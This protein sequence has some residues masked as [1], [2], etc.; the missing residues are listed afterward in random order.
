[1]THSRETSLTS[2]QVFRFASV[3][4]HATKEPR[5]I[6]WTHVY[7]RMHKKGIVG[8]DLAASAASATRPPPS[9]T[10]PLSS[11]DGE[12]GEGGQEG[13][14]CT[15]GW[16]IWPQ[17]VEA[18][19]EGLQSVRAINVDIHP[20]RRCYQHRRYIARPLQLSEG[21]ARAR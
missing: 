9:A 5:K 10:A 3:P 13:Q 4:F 6:A 11:E 19:D 1:M 16:L 8:A 14:A 15:R 2:T 12:E 7:R 17:G 20:E 21:I 18:A